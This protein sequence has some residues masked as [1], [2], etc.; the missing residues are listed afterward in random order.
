M[1]SPPAAAARAPELS[2]RRAPGTAMAF[3]SSSRSCTSA[4]QAAP[5]SST[6]ALNMRW[7]PASAPVWAAA[8]AAPAADSPTFSTATPTPRSAHIR[9]RLAQER[10]VAVRPPGRARSTRRPPPVP[11]RS[12]TRR[13]PPSVEFPHETTVCKPQR[14]PAA[15]AFTA[16]LPLCETS[17]TGPA[18]SGG[19]VS[20]H[21]AAP[22]VQRDDPV[23]VRPAHR[24]SMPSRPP[25]AGRARAR[26]RR[27]PRRTRRR[28][29]P[30]RRSRARRPR[31]EPPRPRPPGF[32]TTTASGP[33]S[34]DSDGKHGR[35][36]APARASGSLPTR[37]PQSPP[38]RRF[39]SVSP[40]YESSRSLAPTTA[41]LRGRSS[42]P[43]SISA[44]CARRRA[45]PGPGR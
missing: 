4:A 32:A 41:T 31:P 27:R 17:A 29:R 11:A 28:T 7:S 8:A 33:R 14:A 30:L 34:S 15:S 23:P 40:A 36:R 22:D 6:S 21:I 1:A 20:P 44:A 10:S 26:R 9:E 24:K 39:S 42:R 19:S 18:A 38:P 35:T 12:P 13:G 16:T 37:A 45:A 2:A 25:R 43:R 5:A 3:A